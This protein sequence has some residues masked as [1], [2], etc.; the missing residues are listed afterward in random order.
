MFGWLVEGNSALEAA[1]KKR[2]KKRRKK[3][4][5]KLKKENLKKIFQRLKTFVY[6]NFFIYVGSRNTDIYGK[7]L[8]VIYLRCTVR[9]IL[10]SSEMLFSSV[11]LLGSGV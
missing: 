9:E 10:F 11:K 7:V 3:N 1:M 8:H 5:T 6:Y 4:K 2:T